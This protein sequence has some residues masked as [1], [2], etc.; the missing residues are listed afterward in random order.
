MSEETI[1]LDLDDAGVATGLPR[2]F[3]TRDQVQGVPYRPVQFRDDD[4]PSALE[5]SAA[6][7]RQT[8]EWLGEPVDVI[9]VHLDYDD[10]EGAPYYDLKLLCNEEDL[11]GAPLALR[12]REQRPSN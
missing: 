1:R 3:D 12:T 7:L 6:W 8:Q 5:R 2:P 4:L 11:A 9:A 10:S